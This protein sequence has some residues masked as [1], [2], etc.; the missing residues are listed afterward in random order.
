[1]FFNFVK[2]HF[3]LTGWLWILVSG[4]I[5]K[6]AVMAHGLDLVAVVAVLVLVIVARIEGR[7]FSEEHTE[8]MD[9]AIRMACRILGRPIP[10]V[11]A[12]TAN[13]TVK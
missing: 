13:Q 4:L 1:M 10:K 11:L 2:N 3:K 12:M 6:I 7:Y 8:W 9:M 5:L